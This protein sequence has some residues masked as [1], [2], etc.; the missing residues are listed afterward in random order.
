MGMIGRRA[1][2]TGVA[3]LGFA[4]A[5]AQLPGRT[6]RIGY[7]GFSANDTSPDAARVWA[8]LVDRLRERGLREGDNLVI[9][10]RFFEGDPERY[11]AIAS[12]LVK[13]RVD[14]VIVSSGAAARAVVQASQGRMPV[15][16][17]FV[18]DPVRTG[19]VASLAHPGGSVTGISNLGDE[20]IPKRIELLKAAV[21]GATRIA[22]ARCPACEASAGRPAT[23]VS[24]RFEGERAAARGLGV[25]LEPLDVNAADDFAAARAALE[26]HPPDALVFGATQVNVKLRADWVALAKALRLPTMAPYGGFG[27][28]LAYGPDPAA[29]MRRGADYAVQILG[30]AKPGDLPMEQP[31][32]FEFIVDLRIARDIGLHVPRTLLLRATRVIE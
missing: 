10:Q 14:L 26:S 18:S 28:M 32:E 4:A 15:V 31:T 22:F 25:T 5:Q 12:E 23:E 16:V 8:G 1:F 9:E 19:L 27:A 24:A 3:A 20:L 17:L 29:I 6:H 13:L 11:A 30:G 21:P 7:I 2:M